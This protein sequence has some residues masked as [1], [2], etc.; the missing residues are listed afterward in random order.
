MT[1]VRKVLVVGG[2]IGGLSATIGLRR[3]GVA[4]D[5]VEV[6][7]KWDVYGVGIIQPGNAIRAMDAL[8]LADRCIAEGFPMTGSRMHD[9]DGNLLAAMDFHRPPGLRADLPIMNALRRPKLHGILTSTVLESGADV[10]LGL[11]VSNLVQTADAVSATFSDGSQRDY[12][13][14]IGADGI[15]SLI[16]TMVF[17]AD[18]RPQYTGQICWRYNLPRPREVDSLWMFIGSRG[19]AGFC[20]LSP[21]LMYILLIEKPPEDDPDRAPKDRLAERFR[22]HLAEFG[23][24]VARVR[25]QITDDDAVVVRPV[26]TIVVAPPWHRGRVVLIGDAAHATSPHVGQGA[27]QAIEDGIVLVEEL[28]RE[29]TVADAL[30]AFMERRYERCKMVVEGSAQIGRWEMHPAPDMDPAGVTVAVTN[31]ASAPL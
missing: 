20:P 6:N 11:T 17:G 25:D 19:K 14:V 8:G 15:N 24:P 28:G 26:D 2:G 29:Q 31:A 7:P 30:D 18:V 3:A 27:A 1:D 16:R 9:R 23:G 10:R 13:L 12:D 21:E 22:E 4:V 5:V